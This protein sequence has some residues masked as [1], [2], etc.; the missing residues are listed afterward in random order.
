MTLDELETPAVIVDLDKLEA[1]IR[2]L[3][4]YLDEHSGDAF[5]SVGVES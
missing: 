5:G 4:G 3:Q 1:N 2:R